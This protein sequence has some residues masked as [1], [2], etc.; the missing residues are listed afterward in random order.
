MKKHAMIEEG[1]K[2]RQEKLLL[3]YAYRYSPKEPN[4]DGEERGAVRRRRDANI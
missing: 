2:K 4:Y 3:D 1:K